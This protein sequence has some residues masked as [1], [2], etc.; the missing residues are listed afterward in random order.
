MKKA[1]VYELIELSKGRSLK[2]NGEWNELIEDKL[3]KLLEYKLGRVF[4]GI[5]KS[6]SSLLEQ[7]IR[8]FC[9][10]DNKQD[11]I[12]GLMTLIDI[13]EKYQDEKY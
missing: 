11:K 9:T 8:D 2:F 1:F 5:S 6:D 7:E 12:K 3:T 10:N 13:V 4:F